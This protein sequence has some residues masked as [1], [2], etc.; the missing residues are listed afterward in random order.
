MS[1]M[2]EILVPVIVPD[3]SFCGKFG[4]VWSCSQLSFIED[5]KYASCNLGF[6]GLLKNKNGEFVKSHKCQDCYRKGPI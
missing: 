5:G 6:K 4:A 3:G 2:I 1:K